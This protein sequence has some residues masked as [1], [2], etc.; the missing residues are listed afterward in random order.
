MRQHRMNSPETSD[1]RMPTRTDL[2]RLRR[3]RAAGGALRRRGS[4]RVGADVRPAR[5]DPGRRLVIAQHRQP[6]GVRRHAVRL[7]VPPAAKP[8][9]PTPV[10]SRRRRR[11][12]STRPSTPIGWRPLPAGRVPGQAFSM[13][14]GAPGAPARSRSTASRGSHHCWRS[15]PHR[16]TRCDGE[17]RP[18]PAGKLATG[19]R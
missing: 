10:P 18:G 19:A 12:C 11:S 14:P 15:W 4:A 7:G 16:T 5:V 8:A 3:D 2:I 6:D 9:P 17:V 1:T 13:W